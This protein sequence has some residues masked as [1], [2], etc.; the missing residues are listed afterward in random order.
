MSGGINREIPQQHVSQVSSQATGEVKQ[1]EKSKFDTLIDKIR[2]MKTEEGNTPKDQKIESAIDNIKMA[3]EFASMDPPQAKEAK[4]FLEAA[5]MD[6]RAA[7]D[8]YGSARTPEDIRDI[9][10]K[11]RVECGFKPQYRSSVGGH[12]VKTNLDETLGI[13][14]QDKVGVNKTPTQ[15]TKELTNKNVIPQTHKDAPKT[16]DCAMERFNMPRGMKRKL[17]RMSQEF[18]VKEEKQAFSELSPAMQRKMAGTGQS[19]SGTRLE[20]GKRVP[21]GKRPAE[22]PPEGEPAA[23]RQRTSYSGRLSTAD[24]NNPFYFSKA[25]KGEVN[26][27]LQKARTAKNPGEASA[28]LRSANEKLSQLGELH[29]ITSNAEVGQ[30]LS[31]LQK[32]VGDAFAQASKLSPK[33]E[34]AMKTGD[35]KLKPEVAKQLLVKL[36]MDE[37]ATKP[38]ISDQERQGMIDGLKKDNAGIFND[39]EVKALT[40]MRDQKT[41]ILTQ[42][43]TSEGVLR[44]YASKS[45]LVN[46]T[47]S[48][49]NSGKVELGKVQNNLNGWTKEQDK[50]FSQIPQEIQNIKMKAST[51][52]GSPENLR[53]MTLLSD[54]EQLHASQNPGKLATTWLEEHKSPQ[55]SLQGVTNAY[56]KAY[57]ENIIIAKKFEAEDTDA[58]GLGHTILMKK[59][60][61]NAEGYQKIMTLADSLNDSVGKASETFGKYYQKDRIKGTF[62][63]EDVKMDDASENAVGELRGKIQSLRR[64]IATIKENPSDFSACLN[65]SKLYFETQLDK[66]ERNLKELETAANK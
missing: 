51:L 29:H 40:E 53:L 64:E 18:E 25:V 49:I 14:L 24:F 15:V 19:Q 36:L 48:D 20:G 55:E 4:K 26:N 5:R 50:Y 60:P 33:E 27:E 34:K 52:A 1:E 11:A 56:T 45:A 17:E 44:Q 13:K 39:P 42:I 32:Q 12:E 9:L 8:T 31:A 41:A 6:L 37:H 61:L 38:Q 63:K 10:N 54:L 30:D 62:L 65:T 66:I 58:L 35:T 46:Q 21:G 47:N 59:D 43:G 23:K 16:D 57:G 28:H 3:K 2:G 22:G 7:T